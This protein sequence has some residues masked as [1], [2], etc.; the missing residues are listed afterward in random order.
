M[1]KEEVVA[2][3]TSSRKYNNNDD[4]DHDG[5]TTGSGSCVNGSESSSNDK[6]VGQTNMNRSW[7]YMLSYWI[8]GLFIGYQNDY[9][10]LHAMFYLPS[11]NVN[12]VVNVV[13]WFII[14]AIIT[15]KAHDII[16]SNGHSSHHGDHETTPSRPPRNICCTLIFGLMNGVIETYIFLGIYD[17][18]KYLSYGSMLVGF[19]FFFCYSGMIHVL[20]WVPLVLPPSQP[21]KSS[22]KSNFLT[23]VL[24]SLTAMS[25]T[26]IGLYE[27]TNGSCIILPCLLHIY[28]DTKLGLSIN[29]P[30]FPWST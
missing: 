19:I 2:T 16:E 18:G 26:W 14:S 9:V 6:V 3:S 24:P 28:V 17:Y 7:Y 4:G 8:F 5:T 25:I 30:T 29:F 11:Y 10:T 1:S 23:H 12:V 22:Q 13:F 27:L 15:V 21:K 20:F